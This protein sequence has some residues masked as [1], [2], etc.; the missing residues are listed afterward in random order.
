MALQCKDALQTLLRFSLQLLLLGFFVYFFGKPAVC[1]YL[2]K[3]V[4]DVKS[5]RDTKGTPAP[6][7][8]IV[9]RNDE[10]QSG[11]K[12]KGQ[13][14]SAGFVQKLCSDANTT[15]SFAS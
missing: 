5:R 2:D 7:V 15:N 1:K 10:T 9:I 11:W 6:A 13:L 3:K 8:T 12:A 4:L 14:G